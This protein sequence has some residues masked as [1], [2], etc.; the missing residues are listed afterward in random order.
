MN[1]S[2]KK[3]ET[4]ATSKKSFIEGVKTYFKEVK[5]E[6]SKITWPERTQVIQE[7]IVVVVVVVFFTV[8]VYALDI[9]YKWLLGFIPSR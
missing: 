7:T 4:Q 3:K 8:F 5:S 9:I 2:I 1:T 6:W